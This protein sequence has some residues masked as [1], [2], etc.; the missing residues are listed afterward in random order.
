[1]S[2]NKLFTSEWARP[3]V[4][5]LAAAVAFGVYTYVNVREERNEVRAK[6]TESEER[7]EEARIENEGLLERLED[8]EEQVG[9]LSGELRKLTG[10][11]NILEK[12]QNTD[13][14]LLQKYSKVYFFK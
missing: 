14:E 4:V 6:F 12:L 13:E 11:V 7:L 2:T 8:E 10:A 9:L 3:T 5:I 1:M